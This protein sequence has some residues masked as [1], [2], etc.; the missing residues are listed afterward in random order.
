[1]KTDANILKK[2]LSNITHTWNLIF[3]II[4]MNLLTK[5]KQTYRH[6]KQIYDYQRGDMGWG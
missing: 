1:M 4:Q 2:I 6:Q 3:K 5:Q